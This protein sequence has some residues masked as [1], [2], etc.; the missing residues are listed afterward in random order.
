[1]KE[2]YLG[3]AICAFIVLVLTITVEVSSSG[4]YL[5]KGSEKVQEVVL[6]KSVTDV[7]NNKLDNSFPTRVYNKNNLNKIFL[8]KYYKNVNYNPENNFYTPN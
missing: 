7:S 3:L 1:M 2:L 5:N 8:E 4:R 6:T